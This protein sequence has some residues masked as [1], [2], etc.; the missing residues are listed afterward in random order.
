VAR[1]G[2]PGVWPEGYAAREPYTPG[3]QE[4]YTGVAASRSVKTARELGVT[5]E[6]TGGRCMIVPGRLETSHADTAYRAM[7]ALLVLTGC[8]SGWAQAGGGS[9]IPL[10]PYLCLHACGEDR[11]DV[12]ALSWALCEGM[13]SRR[14]SRSVLL[15]AVR[16]GWPMAPSPRVLAIPRPIYPLPPEV[17]LLIGPDEQ[18]DLA[19]PDPGLVAEAV[20][21]LAGGAARVDPADS[22]GDGR[23]RLLVDHAWRHEYG[24]ALPTYRPPGMGIPL[25]PTQLVRFT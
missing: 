17:D 6:K 12:G 18:C 22:P 5:A 23:M 19:P 1:E 3:W 8:G 25:K 21:R 7:L 10:V 16:D 20:A 14:T 11:A 9:G 13:F 15:E 4:A 24:E 2:L